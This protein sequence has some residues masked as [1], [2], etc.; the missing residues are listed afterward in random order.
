M[1]GQW[2]ASVQRARRA[3]GLQAR[4]PDR[5]PDHYL[6]LLRSS[7]RGL[8]ERAGNPVLSA[9]EVALLR[10]FAAYGDVIEAHWDE[11]EKACGMLPRT[12]VHGD[13][14][15][16]NLR[17]RT[18]TTGPALLVFDWEMAG[19]GAPATDLAQFVGR[20]ASPELNVYWSE[21][22]NGFPQLDL[23][24]I[25]RLADYG[26]LLRMLDK[27]FWA[28]VSMEGSSYEFLVNPISHLRSYEPELVGALRAVNWR[29]A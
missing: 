2:L 25:Q 23:S 11:V 14:V 28:T 19:W 29:C 4:L 16:K 12:L 7:R 3:S 18:G 15:I 17:V 9:D 10:R 26:G 8:L 5:G 22:R 27:V 24:D 1:A 6:Q 13:F 21:V 20:C